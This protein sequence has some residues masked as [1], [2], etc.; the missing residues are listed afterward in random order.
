MSK[1]PIFYLLVTLVV[2]L[3]FVF[4]LFFLKTSSYRNEKLLNQSNSYSDLSELAG[5]VKFLGYE[6]LFIPE[7]GKFILADLNNMTITLYFL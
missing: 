5:T 2:L 4:F 6:D 7:K 3:V 1:K